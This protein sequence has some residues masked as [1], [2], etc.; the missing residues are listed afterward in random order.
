MNVVMN[1]RS[2]AGRRCKD[3]ILP[4]PLP[5]FLSAFVYVCVCVWFAS[6]CLRP[7]R[8]ISCK[9]RYHRGIFFCCLDFH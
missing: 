2:L 7:T 8:S 4:L 1:V 6:F 9:S 3:S 5:V